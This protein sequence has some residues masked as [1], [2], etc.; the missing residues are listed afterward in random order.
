MLTVKLPTD[1]TFGNKMH[2]IIIT[3]NNVIFYLFTWA[4]NKKSSVAAQGI[5]A[6][7]SSNND[8]YSV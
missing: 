7:L 6:Y 1:F 2:F 8:F 3:N 5:K 4:F